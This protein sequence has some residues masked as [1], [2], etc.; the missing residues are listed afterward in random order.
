MTFD[1]WWKAKDEE[2]YYVNQPPALTTIEEVKEIAKKAWETA[3]K[4]VL[5]EQ[6]KRD[7]IKRSGLTS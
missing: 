1:E 4:R 6:K 7:F 2:G 3:Q 5:E